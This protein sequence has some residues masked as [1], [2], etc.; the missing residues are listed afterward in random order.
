M[1]NIS[2]G[3]LLIKTCSYYDLVIRYGQVGNNTNAVNLLLL[4]PWMKQCG[5]WSSFATF[6]LFPACPKVTART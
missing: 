3:G 6:G 4:Y 2:K 5:S 1:G